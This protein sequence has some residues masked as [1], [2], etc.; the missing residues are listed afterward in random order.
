MSDKKT[1]KQANAGDRAARAE[2]RF[3]AAM[4]AIADAFYAVDANW[5]VVVFNAAAERYFGFSAGEV[6]QRNLWEIF[7]QGRGR[8]YEEMCRKAKEDGVRSTLVMPS[9]LRPGRS[10]EI[11]FAP[12]DD[13][14][15]VA[16]TDITDRMTKE[17][18][19]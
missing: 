19:V 10:V 5:Q 1:P 3:D 8:P 17:A 7:P 9:A 12:W 2:R 6:L 4:G 13:G 18:Q 11:T 14:M 15:C 16:I